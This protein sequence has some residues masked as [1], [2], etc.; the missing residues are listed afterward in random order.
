MNIS[1]NSG[2]KKI[3]HSLI[4]MYVIILPWYFPA[5]IDALLLCLLGVPIAG[6]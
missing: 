4:N 2:V 1:L 5:L 6:S 3:L